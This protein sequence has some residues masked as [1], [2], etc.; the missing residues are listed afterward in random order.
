MKLSGEQRRVY[1]HNGPEDQGGHLYVYV[2]LN[3]RSFRIPR[4]KEVN[5]PVEVVEILKNAIT[6]E[7]IQKRDRRTGEVETVFN[8]IMR[9]P[10][11]DRGPVIKEPE[12]EE[13]P[14]KEKA[15]KAA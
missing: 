6:T 2:G 15:A 10:F 7:V 12:K 9:F 4:M 11:E 13:P 8:D 14:P 3:G 1:I 5:L